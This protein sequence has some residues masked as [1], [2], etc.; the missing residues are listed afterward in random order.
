MY[1]IYILQ[2]LKDNRTYVGY[3]ADVNRRLSEH[4]NGKVTATKNRK[5]FKII[6]T[7]KI[8]TLGEAKKRELYWKSRAGRKK[9]ERLFT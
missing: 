1:T 4:N 7:E 9:M 3:S 8:D 5:P 6:F 2:S